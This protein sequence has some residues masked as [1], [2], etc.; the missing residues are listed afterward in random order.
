MYNK[1]LVLQ[2][3][4]DDIIRERKRLEEI[5]M[6]QQNNTSRQTI[7]ASKNKRYDLNELRHH[8]RRCAALLFGARQQGEHQVP[9]LV[10][11]VTGFFLK[12]MFRPTL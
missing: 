6:K 5:M 10:S 7:N 8:Q 4:E 1:Y 2:K 11:H 12:N 3:I 9:Y